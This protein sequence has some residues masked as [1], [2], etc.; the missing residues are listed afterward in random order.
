MSIVWLAQL[1][2]TRA[3]RARQYRMSEY[4]DQSFKEILLPRQVTADYN[5]IEGN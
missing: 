5:L 4:V 3:M 2:D 1:A